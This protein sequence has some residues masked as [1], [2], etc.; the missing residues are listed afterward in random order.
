MLVQILRWLLLVAEVW[1]GGIILYFDILSIAA[2]LAAKKQRSEG[3]RISSPLDTSLSRPMSFAILIPAH[4]EEAMLGALLESLSRLAYPKDKYTVYVVADNCTDSTAEIARAT[5]WVHVYERVDEVKRGKG[6]ALDWIFSELEAAQLIY[7]AYVIFDADSVVVPTY[8]QAIERELA[9]GAQA[10]QGHVI[11]M[12]ATA[13]SSTVL[14]WIALTLVAHVRSL[15]RNALGASSIVGTGMCLSRALLMRHP[16]RAFSLTEDYEYYL[17][18]VQ[19]GECVRYVPEAA[20]HTHMATTFAQMRTQD[21]RWESSAGRQPT[22]QVAF[23]LLRDGL[24]FRD[25]VRLEA[26]AELLTPPLSFL[27]CSCLFLLILSLLVWSPLE[28][29]CSLMLNIGLICYVSTALYMLRPP[30][31]VYLAFLHVPGFILWKMWVYLVL[32]RSKKHTSEWV[33]TSR[34]ISAD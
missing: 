19:H 22:W 11:V 13:S 15:G 32:S 20:V 34:T 9:Q 3:T 31:S 24:R 33:R 26:I 27:V 17:T 6:Y 16:W 18:L 12:N 14:R 8:L 7:D 29:L 1:I 5:G 30:R 23:R 4:N 28:L 25:F 10:V 2:I 21:I